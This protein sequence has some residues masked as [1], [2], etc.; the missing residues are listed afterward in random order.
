MKKTGNSSIKSHYYFNLSLN[1]LFQYDK[2]T[3]K[4]VASKQWELL[5]ADS[6]KSFGS[7]KSQYQNEIRDNHLDKPLRQLTFVLQKT[8]N[9]RKSDIY[10]IFNAYNIQPI[11]ESLLRNVEKNYGESD[12]IQYD[13]RTSEIARLML[14]LSLDYLKNSAMFKEISS[15]KEISNSLSKDFKILSKSMLEKEDGSQTISE[16]EQNKISSKYLEIQKKIQSYPTETKI[17]LYLEIQQLDFEYIELKKLNR[18][19]YM[20]DNRTKKKEAYDKY[21]KR[22]DF[23]SNLK[24]NEYRNESKLRLELNRKYDHISNYFSRKSKLNY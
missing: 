8:K 4:K 17:E 7:K 24:N 15:V 5:M 3:K 12:S 9:L 2:K 14:E 22:V 20:K 21:K 11:L 18:K 1:P 6:L 10:E 13:F 16:E 23:E 19:E